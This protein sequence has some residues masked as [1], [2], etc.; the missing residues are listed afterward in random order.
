MLGAFLPTNGPAIIDRLCR[1]CRDLQI[2]TVMVRVIAIAIQSMFR[3]ELNNLQRALRAVDVGNIDV[4]LKRSC[5]SRRMRPQT[6]CED[7]NPRRILNSCGHRPGAAI[8]LSGRYF[9]IGRQLRTGVHSQCDSVVS[10]MKDCLFH[11]HMEF[12]STF[13]FGDKVTGHARVG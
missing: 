4:G 11:L 1:V 5:G 3:H 2:R 13:E 12:L 9:G 8:S 6:I 7:G 10:G